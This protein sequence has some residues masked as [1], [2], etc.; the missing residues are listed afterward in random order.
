[1]AHS[2]VGIIQVVENEEKKFFYNGQKTG[3]S[4]SSKL[5]I[6]KGVKYISNL[7]PNKKLV[8]YLTA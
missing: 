8:C 2:S 6:I 7:S 3:N 1:V 5:P 4:I